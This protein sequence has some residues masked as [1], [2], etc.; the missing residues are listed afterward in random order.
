MKQIDL[1]QYKK[2]QEK[3][4]KVPEN[5]FGNFTENLMSRIPEEKVVPD[6]NTLSSPACGEEK[7]TLFTRIKPYLYLAAMI[8]GIAFGVKVYKFQQQ[9]YTQPAESGTM[10]MTDEQ[11]EQYVDYVCDFAMISSNDVYACVADNYENLK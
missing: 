5:Y 10:A 2:R 3:P 8:C 6:N 9:Y 1:D 7:I 11:A 4:F